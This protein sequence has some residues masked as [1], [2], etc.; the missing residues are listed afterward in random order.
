MLAE[1]A[2]RSAKYEWLAAANLYQEALD[3][4]STGRDLL[5]TAQISD[6]KAR[7]QFKAGFQAGTREEFKQRMQLA[8]ESFDKG[9]VLYEGAGSK[10]LADRS[11]A[12]RLF[13]FYWIIEDATERR[14]LLERSISLAHQALAG[15][16]SQ[17]DR[18]EIAQ[19]H[20]DLLEY[21]IE[22]CEATQDSKVVKER[23]ERI[24]PMGDNLVQEFDGLGKNEDLVVC[25]CWTA[26]ILGLYSTRV[27]L[28][29]FRALFE[30]YAKQIYAFLKG[31][32]HPSRFPLQREWLA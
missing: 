9:V 6:L 14:K 3:Q 32:V 25:L 8:Q 5:E 26:G 22:A 21:S 2:Q 4:Q 24:A 11:R 16:G 10:A 19:T 1:A 28:S 7:S 29:D 13:S 12:R 20:M 31:Q 18:R 27:D 30:E 17:Q 23:F 15:L